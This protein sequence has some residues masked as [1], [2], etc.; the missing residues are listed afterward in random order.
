MGTGADVCFT[1][2]SAGCVRMTQLGQC[3]FMATFYWLTQVL[4]LHRRTNELKHDKK[5]ST[6]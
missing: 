1:V 6:L 2:V 4:H 3:C 5:D